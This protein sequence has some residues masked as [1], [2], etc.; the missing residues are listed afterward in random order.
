MMMVMVFCISKGGLVLGQTLL[1]YPTL[2]DGFL[3]YGAAIDANPKVI[4]P[5]KVVK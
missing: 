1:K 4:T 2:C 5:F 3:M